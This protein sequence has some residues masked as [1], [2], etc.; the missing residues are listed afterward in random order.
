MDIDEATLVDRC[1]GGDDLAWEWLVR[2]CQGRVYGLAYHYLGS[3]E[4]ARDVAQEAF[5]RVYRQ[6]GSF[7]GDRFMAW[8]LRITRNLCID[9]LRRRKTRPP[10]EGVR[11]DADD[12]T[13]PRDAAPDPEQAWL[14]DA[15]RRLVHR[16][17][18]RL[19]GAN[20]EVILLKDIQGL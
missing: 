16:A 9:Q 10:A 17:L 11:A 19:D 3:V 6:L 20:R 12:D 13:A 8:L 15:R 2:R 7:E 5:V 18:Q 1:R 4:D 14:A